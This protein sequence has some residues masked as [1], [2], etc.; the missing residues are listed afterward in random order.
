MKLCKIS[1]DELPKVVYLIFRVSGL[2]A[3]SQVEWRVYLDPWTLGQQGILEFKSKEHCV[4]PCAKQDT[5]D[6]T[7]D[8]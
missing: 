1:G 2:G 8:D 5:R 4:T 6:A 3:S 7:K